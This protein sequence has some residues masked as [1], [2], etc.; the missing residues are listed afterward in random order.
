MN[1]NKK[2]KQDNKSVNDDTS[3]DVTIVRSQAKPNEP[4]EIS[5]Q[6]QSKEGLVTYDY[7]RPFILELELTWKCNLKCYHCYVDAAEDTRCNELTFDEIKKIIDDGVDIGISELSLTGGEVFLC[8]HFFETL[9]YGHKKGMG[10]RF[11]TNGTLIT[12]EI[13]ERLKNLPIKL[14][15]ISLDADDKDTHNKIRGCDC[16]SETVTT[17]DKLL[18]SGYRISI[19]TAFSKDNLPFFDKTLQFCKDRKIDWQVQMTSQKGRCTMEHLL[20]PDQYYQLGE[21]VASAIYK[22]LP[23]HII[24]MDD[25]ATFSRFFPLSILSSTWQEGCSGGKLNMFVRADGSVTPCSAIS[26][27]PFIAGNIRDTNLK[28]ICEKEMCKPCMKEWLDPSLL[29]GTCSTCPHKEVCRGGCPEILCTMCD[30]KRE[31]KYCYWKIEEERIK[32]DLKD[33]WD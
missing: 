9:K 2:T 32:T 12:D 20:T 24:P 28:T 29:T 33:I 11:V 23:M 3:D 21:Q 17:I 7:K 31:N 13:I 18:G 14:I 8:D 30:S 15:T 1:N 16:Y 10:L 25:L 22:G 5:Y 19:I 4:V 6:Q 26:F 27:E